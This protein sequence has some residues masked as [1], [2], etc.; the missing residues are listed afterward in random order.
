MEYQ[1][2]YTTY[3]EM[4]AD[5]ICQILA[6]QGIPSRVQSRRVGGYEAIAIGPLG[7]IRILVPEPYREKAQRL[8]REAIADGVLW[9]LGAPLPEEKVG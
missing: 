7:E 6:G 1:A 5:R 9:P 8:I 3:E 2:V 4:H